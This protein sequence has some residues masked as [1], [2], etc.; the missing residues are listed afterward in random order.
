[1]QQGQ[2]QAAR[3]EVVHEPVQAERGALLA[4]RAD[5]HV[6]VGANAEVGLAPAAHPIELGAVLNGP[7]PHGS[8]S[9]SLVCR[10]SGVSGSLGHTRFIVA[11]MLRSTWERMAW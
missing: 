3:L 10:Q 6:A 4:A 11:S 9:T 8:S 5:E 1:D 2:R 7:R